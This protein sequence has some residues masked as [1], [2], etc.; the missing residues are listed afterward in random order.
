MAMLRF[1]PCVPQLRPSLIQHTGFNPAPVD[2]DALLAK[3]EAEYETK[4]AA[5]RDFQAPKPIGML[6]EARHEDEEAEGE[7]EAE[8]EVEEDDEMDAT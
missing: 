4:M 1:P 7:E 8:E 2:E 5:V 3:E 6:S